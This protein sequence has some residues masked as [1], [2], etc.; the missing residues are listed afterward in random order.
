MRSYT[1]GITHKTLIALEIGHTTHV[2]SQ[3]AADQKREIFL[4]AVILKASI[5]G[6]GSG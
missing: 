3:I 1:H 5:K 4:W 6:T 2:Q